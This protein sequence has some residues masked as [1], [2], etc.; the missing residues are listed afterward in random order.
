VIALA[1]VALRWQKIARTGAAAAHLS[2]AADVGGK[3]S[4]ALPR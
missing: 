4:P 1:G 3:P 2:K